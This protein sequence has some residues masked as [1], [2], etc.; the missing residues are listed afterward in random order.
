M[1]Y[2][3]TENPYYRLLDVYG[4]VEAWILTS[5]SMDKLVLMYS[6][7]VYENINRHSQVYLDH[8]KLNLYMYVKECS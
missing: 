6:R 8:F 2:E 3:T 4:L 1:S 7:I 5:S